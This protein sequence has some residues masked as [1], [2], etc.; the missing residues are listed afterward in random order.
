MT[1]NF[2]E[3]LSMTTLEI[4]EISGK[5]HKNVLRDLKV[6]KIPATETS[7]KDAMG[8]EQK[9]FFLSK[10]QTHAFLLSYNQETRVGVFEKLSKKERAFSQMVE[11]KANDVLLADVEL[12]ALREEV[13]TLR[14]ANEELKL[15]VW[16][17]QATK[18]QCADVE[19]VSML[20]I[21]I[22]AE[23]DKNLLE[24]MLAGA[25]YIANEAIA[26]EK[27]CASN[28]SYEARRGIKDFK[29]RHDALRPIE[30]LLLSGYAAMSTVKRLHDLG[31]KSNHRLGIR[32]D[33]YNKGNGHPLLEAYNATLASMEQSYNEG[34]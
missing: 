2:A 17:L 18:A 20:T 31:V 14:A 21:L 30:P 24:D 15:V 19:N 23:R 22:V 4:A 3:N 26:L 1:E 27:E 25:A 29:A 5:Q 8:R 16:R 9:V 32:A 6:S 7:Y 28:L 10:A 33:T 13:K 12:R 34:F 11:R